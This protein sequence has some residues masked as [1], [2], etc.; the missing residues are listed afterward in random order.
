MK[1][2]T[3]SGVVVALAWVGCMPVA[4]AQKGMGDATGLARRGVTPE[5]VLLSGS[6]AE[7][8]TGPCEKG[9]GRGEIGTHILVKG[10]GPEPW[11]VHLGWSVAVE[12]IAGRLTIGQPLA[13]AAFRTDK[14][15]AG[16][17]VA[18]SV[19]IDGQTMELRDDRLRPFWAGNSRNSENARGMRPANRARRFRGGGASRRSGPVI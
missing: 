5:T 16:H 12:Q 17:Y 2:G 14:M 19:T 7:V 15:P 4:F 13:I 9:T 6:L 18:K 10:D 1:A 8:L 11:N 3:I